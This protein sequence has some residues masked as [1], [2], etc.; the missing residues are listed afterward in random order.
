MTPT[1]TA[2]DPAVF[3]ADVRAFAAER[4]VTGYLAPLH[5]LAKCCFHGANVSVLLDDDAEIPGLRWIVFKVAAGRWP[6]EPR[7]TGR[8][9]WVEEFDRTTPP[10]VRECFV[11]GL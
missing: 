1:V 4:I 2:P 8:R 6:D 10:A 7:R 9:R 3:P 5:D 11:L